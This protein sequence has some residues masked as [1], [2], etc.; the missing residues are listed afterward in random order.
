MADDSLKAA[1]HEARMSVPALLRDVSPEALEKSVMPTL[2]KPWPEGCRAAFKTLLGTE[3]GPSQSLATPSR[4][5]HM[6]TESLPLLQEDQYVVCK[7][8]RRPVLL[9]VFDDHVR[10]CS[11]LPPP[12]AASPGD[13]LRAGSPSAPRAPPSWRRSPSTSRSPLQTRAGTCPRR[14][15]RQTPGSRC[16]TQTSM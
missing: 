5:K 9:E 13:E 4:R 10:V 3:A 2:L 14:S 12:R 15:S 6:R 11:S 1:V 7:T 8:C 16:S